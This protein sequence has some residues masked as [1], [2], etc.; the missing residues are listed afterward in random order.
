MP[1]ANPVKKE[2]LLLQGYAIQR[3]HVNRD[4]QFVCFATAKNDSF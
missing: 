1:I 3:F 2:I 4:I